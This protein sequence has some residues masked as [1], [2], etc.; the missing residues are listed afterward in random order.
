M[1]ASHPPTG[2]SAGWSGPSPITPARSL[3]PLHSTH[4][5]GCQ[6]LY[7]CQSPYWTVTCRGQGLCLALGE[8][9]VRVAHVCRK[10]V[11]AWTD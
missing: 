6:D 7:P 5:T 3:S 9:P 2:G 8:R 4:H 11:R 10:E 1:H